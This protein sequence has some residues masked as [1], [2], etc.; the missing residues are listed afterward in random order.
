M[1]GVF[2][3][4]RF[5]LDPPFLVW[6]KG[7]VKAVGLFI[8]AMFVGGAMAGQQD[9]PTAQV[10]VRK[11]ALFKNGYNW[12]ELTATLP[13]AELV[14]LAGMPN[15]L[16]GT[17]WW[18]SGTGVVSLKGSTRECTVPEVGYSCAEL[19]AAN[20]GKWVKLTL[21]GGR[22]TEG[23]LPPRQQEQTPEGSF[24]TTPDESGSVAPRVVMLQ[25]HTGDIGVRA[26]DVVGVEAATGET[27]QVPTR[28]ENVPVVSARLTKPSPGATF[29]F[30]YVSNSMSWLPEYSLELGQDGL[31]TLTARANIINEMADMN[32]VQLQ[33][34]SGFPAL[35]DA[36]IDSP[37]NRNVKLGE[38]LRKLGVTTWETRKT[39]A[40]AGN[41]VAYQARAADAFAE[42]DMDGAPEEGREG[43]TKRV[44][45]LFYYTLP[46]FTCARGQSLIREIFTEQ[47]PY[48][49]IYTCTVP[50]QNALE[51]LSNRGEPVADIWH[52]V[53]LKNTGKQTW[54]TGIVTCTQESNLVARSTL[55]FAAPGGETLLRLNKTLQAD[56]LCRE[57]LSNREERPEKGKDRD[58]TV[59]VS[60]YTGVLTLKNN[61]DR[62]MPVRLTKQVEGY[63]K[64]ADG[65]A[66]ITVS[67]SYSGNPR[68][69]IIWE[70]TLRPGE[71]LER[72]YSYEYEEE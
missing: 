8:L 9:V 2:S 22:V 67:P 43:D 47:V 69:K 13:D 51:R 19:L 5:V 70:F 15:V 56:V 66:N 18:D 53:K 65:D 16:L 37:L 57:E 36:L 54:S 62:E 59:T 3:N 72:T 45:D 35:G 32:D 10:Q 29:T 55:Y 24:L 25:T 38:L 21:S 17:V 46:H 27:L 64:T 39:R 52:C 1:W 68:S 41:A 44:E 14:Q 34:V 31:A 11:V 49:H 42:E 20:A 26:E 7:N 12:V 60:T 58:K 30:G 23:T 33:L 6:Y 71:T 4:I 48:S 50:D 28:K 61:M 40:P 63:A